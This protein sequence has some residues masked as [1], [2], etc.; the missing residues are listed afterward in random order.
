MNQHPAYRGQV[1][2]IIA[3][4]SVGKLNHITCPEDGG[5]FFFHSH[6]H[7]SSWINLQVQTQTFYTCIKFMFNEMKSI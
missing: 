7:L 4:V 3:L 5:F 2:T 1:F 6:P